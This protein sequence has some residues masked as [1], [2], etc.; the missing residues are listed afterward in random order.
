MLCHSHS[1]AR[2]N[3][4][5]KLIFIAH[6]HRIIGQIPFENGWPWNYFHGK[7]AL[8]HFMAYDI[9][10]SFLCNRNILPWP[11]FLSKM[12]DRY[13]SRPNCTFSFHDIWHSKLIFIIQDY[14]TMDDLENAFQGQIAIYSFMAYD[15]GLY[16][17]RGHLHVS[18]WS[19]LT[20]WTFQGHVPYD[21]DNF[22]GIVYIML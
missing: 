8:F 16:Q 17:P 7:I 22:S 21:E 4:Y 14:F 5:I 15:I 18:V 9:Q 13:F 20:L 11:R 19:C 2:N 6:E 1:R 10:S 3:M 12:G